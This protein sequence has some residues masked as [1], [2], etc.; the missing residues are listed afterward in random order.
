MHNLGSGRKP[1]LFGGSPSPIA[2]YVVVLLTTA[3]LSPLVSFFPPSLTMCFLLLV[4]D[5]WPSFSHHGTRAKQHPLK[6]SSLLPWQ[7]FN[8][9]NLSCGC[10]C[11]HQSS[12]FDNYLQLFSLEQCTWVKCGTVELAGTLVSQGPGC[13][14]TSQSAQ[15]NP[16]TTEDHS[17]RPAVM[18]LR[19]SA[20]LR[21]KPFV[22]SKWPK[23]KDGKRTLYS[24]R[25]DTYLKINILSLGIVEWT[26]MSSVCCCTTVFY[27]F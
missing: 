21:D 26:C 8:Q 7:T 18:M 13:C 23:L 25:P 2:M 27:T 14:S 9:V 17:K 16:M 22:C 15:G 10:S 20:K 5:S 11:S 6:H 24:E 12:V 19:T 1:P 4:K 3:T